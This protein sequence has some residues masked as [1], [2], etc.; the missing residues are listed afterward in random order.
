MG[1]QHRSK[2]EGRLADL[3]RRLGEAEETLRAIRGGEVDALV[4]NTPEG[5]QVFTLRGAEATYRTLVEAM[6]EGALLLMPDGIVLYANTRFGSMAEAPLDQIIGTP[7]ARFFP[8]DEVAKF[9]SLLKRATHAGVSEEFQLRVSNDRFCPVWISLASTKSAGIDGFSAVI[10]DL[11]E[12][13]AAEA[14]VRE[15]IGE[16][17]GVSYA[18]VHDM[19]APLRAMEAFAYMLEQDSEQHSPAQRKDL[20]RRI[21]VA[22]AR[23]DEL[24]RDALTYNQVVLKPTTLHPVKLSKLFQEM[25]E[26]YPNLSPEKADIDL[27]NE[28][29]LVLG[30]EAMLTQCFA[31]LL[32]NAVKFVP[33]G[34]RPRVKVRAEPV[35]GM[36]RI[37]VEDNGIGI[38]DH[39]KERL[40]RM[41]QRLTSEYEGTG[42]GLAIVRKVA[43]RMGG[44]VGAESQPGKG[45]RFWVELR[46]V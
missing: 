5:E 21:T 1:V 11:T 28:L 18:I 44:K 10:T 7:I 32:G 37:W 30:N 33:E 45:S 25:L 31:N 38:P 40:F 2:Q 15:M 4:V 36:A 6:N 35:N 29:P 24:I 9:V 27:E 20:A 34:V 16:L 26:T 23:M 46:T 13:K 43:E 14:K 41:F 3:E 12:R 8:E 42:I 19:R 22:A 39:A 17:E